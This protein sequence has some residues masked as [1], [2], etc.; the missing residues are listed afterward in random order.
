MDGQ[1]PPKVTE[2]QVAE[3]ACRKKPVASGRVELPAQWKEL[4]ESKF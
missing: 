2:T 4:R 1:C 3:K